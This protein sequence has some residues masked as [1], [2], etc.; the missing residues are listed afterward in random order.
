MKIALDAGHG[1]KD[2]G[3]VYNQRY[4]KNDNLKLTLAVGEILSQNG[5]DVIY[6]RDSD[7]YE[8]PIKKA[9][10][11]N[12]AN[13]DYFISFHRNSSEYPNKYSGAEV[14]LY[15]ET[16]IKNQM[17]DNILKGME[18]AGFRNLGKDIR[19][20]LVV[21]KR[22]K[23]PALLIEAGF[24]N[25][26]ADNKIFDENFDLLAEGIAAGILNAVNPKEKM[27]LMEEG[28]NDR[29]TP[30]ASPRIVEMQSG[31]YAAYLDK[32]PNNSCGCMEVLYRVQVG[33]FRN[34]DYADRLLNSLLAQEYPAYIV[35]DNDLYKVQ[36][37][38]FKNLSNAVRMEYTLRQSKYN[39]YITT[40]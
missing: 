37:G 32:R 19:K 9:S 17:A 39:T 27:V 33:A 35:F 1:A 40:K 18:E 30:E 11:A 20:D 16:G 29:K 36:V 15:N 23:M 7:I 34:R 24:I 22:T 26:D 2:P 12:D 31:D 13:A 10:D 8:T 21:L 3:S 38:A 14:L 6:T 28:E 4:E 25:S 5:V